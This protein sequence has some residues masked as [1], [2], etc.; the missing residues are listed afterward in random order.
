MSPLDGIVRKATP[1]EKALCRL[2]LGQGKPIPEDATEWEKR[3]VWVLE[4]NG[5]ISGCLCA[6]QVWQLE[7]LYLFPDFAADAPPLTVRRGIVKLLQAFEAW[8]RDKKACW[9]FCYIE[10]KPMQRMAR[11]WGMFPVYRKGKMFGKD[12]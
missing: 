1:E 6:R 2:K 11:S 8:M 4:H 12:V 5:I 3:E 9:Y 10:K 7:P